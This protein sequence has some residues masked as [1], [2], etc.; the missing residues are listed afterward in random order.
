MAPCQQPQ[1]MT[2]VALLIALLS[3]QLRSRSEACGLDLR[4]GHQL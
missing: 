4:L 1:R 2:W 3:N